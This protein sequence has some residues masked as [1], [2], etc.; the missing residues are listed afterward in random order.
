M[1]LK[2]DFSLLDHTTKKNCLN[3]VKISLQTPDCFLRIL[4]R[5]ISHWI[6]STCCRR[7]TEKHLQGRKKDKSRRLKV[8][9]RSRKSNMSRELTARCWRFVLRV[10]TKTKWLHGASS[11]SEPDHHSANADAI[12]KEKNLK[13]QKADALIPTFDPADLNAEQRFYLFIC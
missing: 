8:E 13:R 6:S 12:K 11:V 10:N 3:M 2:Q 9:N 4:T 5:F 7:G 1:R